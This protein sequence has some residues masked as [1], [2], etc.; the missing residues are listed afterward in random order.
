MRIALHN[1]EPRAKMT[2]VRLPPIRSMHFILNEVSFT[3]IPLRT[4]TNKEC[5]R[6][7][8]FR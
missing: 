6:A 8:N 1:T 2:P 5:F 4:D 7:V 3:L